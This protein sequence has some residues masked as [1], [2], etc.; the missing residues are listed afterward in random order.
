MTRFFLA[1]LVLALAGTAFAQPARVAESR[2]IPGRYIVVFNES[3]ANPDADSERKVHALDGR[4]H[5]TFTK[6][7]KGFAATLSDDAVQ[8]LRADPDVAYIEQ[9][10][11]VHATDVENVATW[12]LDRIDQADRPL[13]T[14]Y[15]YNYTGSGVYA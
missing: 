6:V 5:H 9:D 8:R 4:R 3:V 1:L 2:P 12:G 10:Q 11:T 14:Q 15:H 7:V 13:D